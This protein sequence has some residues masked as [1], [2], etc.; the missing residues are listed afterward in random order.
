M[1]FPPRPNGPRNSGGSG[2]CGVQKGLS[3]D[4]IRIG[5]WAIDQ[6]IFA[7]RAY[8]YAQSFAHTDTFAFPPI[9]SY[10]SFPH[11][12][13]RSNEFSS[14]YTPDFFFLDPPIPVSY[15]DTPVDCIEFDKM[16]IL[17]LETLRY[18]I[19]GY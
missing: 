11:F 3:Y 18:D 2:R 8:I 4:S 15:F 6:E 9:F 19:Y 12:F 7:P 10:I 13:H 16:K 1:S 5:S 14:E 17:L